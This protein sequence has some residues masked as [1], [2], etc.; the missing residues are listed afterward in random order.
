MDHFVVGAQANPADEAFVVA[1]HLKTIVEALKENNTDRGGLY[2][3]LVS[4]AYTLQ[5]E[6]EAAIAQIN[7]DNLEYL[8]PKWEDAKAIARQAKREFETAFNQRLRYMNGEL[9]ANDKLTNAVKRLSL[10]KNNPPSPNSYPTHDEIKAWEQA[11]SDGQAA[12]DKLHDEAVVAARDS[13]VFFADLNA[14]E[15]KFNAA[16]RAELELRQKVERLQGKPASSVHG[17]PT[18]VG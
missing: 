16:A 2:Q 5:A 6:I 1:L 18:V 8:L 10:L 4:R 15:T 12:V 17:L 3:Q 14:L 11:V 13:Q 7:S 9:A